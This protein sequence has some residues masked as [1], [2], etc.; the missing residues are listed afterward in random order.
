MSD[1]VESVGFRLDLRSRHR[2]GILKGPSAGPPVR[3]AVWIC[4]GRR[5]SQQTG[6]VVKPDGS[7]GV[8]ASEVMI[9]N[10]P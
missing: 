7:A 3:L 4:Q 10:K 9:K 6:H 1:E 8:A 5:S 2:G